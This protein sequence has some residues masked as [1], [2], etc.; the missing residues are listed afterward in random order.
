M[1]DFN[2]YKLKLIHKVIEDFY[3]FGGGDNANTV[4]DIIFT[5]TDFDPFT[6]KIEGGNGEVKND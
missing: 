1:T 5:I 2:D 6:K 4:L 3:E